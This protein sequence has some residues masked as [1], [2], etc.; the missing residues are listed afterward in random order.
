MG[1]EKLLARIIREFIG[2]KKRALLKN[3]SVTLAAKI[4]S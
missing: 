1:I 2:E 3:I 4:G